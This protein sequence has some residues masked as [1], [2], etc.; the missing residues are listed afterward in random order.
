MV[1]TFIIA[2][3][4]ANHSHKLD[5]A[6]ETIKAAA[7][8]GADAIKLQT[9][10]ADSLTLNVR[11]D[12]FKL[13]GGLWDGRYF[14]DLYQEAFTPWEWHEELFRV[15]KEEG[16]VCFS[17]PFDN[18]AVDLLASLDNPIYK[19]ASFEI[20]DIELIHYA[21]SKGKPMVMSTGIA[22][23]EE[24]NQAINACHEEG[25][26]DVT[27]LKC[28]SAYPAK[29]SDACLSM[30]S[31]LREEF[32]LPVGLSDHGPG[33]LLPVMAVA[34]G[35]TMI[36]KHFIL[37][38][39]IGGPDA[40]FSMDLN[41]FSQMVKDVRNA[42]SAIGEVSFDLTPTMKA[43]RHA[44]RS[45]YVAK[46]IKAGEIVTSENVRCVRPGY[47]LHPSYWHKIVGQPVTIDLNPGD[48]LTLDAIKL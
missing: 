47:S 39:A 2:E 20:A 12:D 4:S 29:F 13:K 36:E 5:I 19:I 17:T 1:K 42:E 33:S 3:L 22:T 6:I 15:A 46:P 11:A 31:A 35:A 30:V 21:A 25:N 10:T 38:R 27:L 9:Y 8:A 43:G 24:I 18:A 23:H 28:T 44:G 26:F 32:G 45:L 14:Y 37:D 48:R 34:M 7:K 16:L 41:E 40:A